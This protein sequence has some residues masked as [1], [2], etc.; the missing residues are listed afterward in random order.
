MQFDIFQ[1]TDL[2]QIHVKF[3]GDIEKSNSL[4]ISWFST[5]YKEVV[6]V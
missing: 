3:M 5:P 2:A 6:S 4:T 1:C